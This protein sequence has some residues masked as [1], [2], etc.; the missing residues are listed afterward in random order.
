MSVHPFRPLFVE[1]PRDA[2]RRSG[3]LDTSSLAFMF[4]TF[5]ATQPV[6]STCQHPTAY[7]C[8]ACE[9]PHCMDCNAPH[10]PGDRGVTTA[11]RWCVGCRDRGAYTADTGNCPRC[12]A[13]ITPVRRCRCGWK[14]DE[15]P[16]G[17][18]AEPQAMT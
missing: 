6:L 2:K 9:K 15:M 11:V 18:D 5:Y 12:E 13:S 14:A 16:R 1:V 4:K 8:A 10:D 7:Q 3:A 17:H